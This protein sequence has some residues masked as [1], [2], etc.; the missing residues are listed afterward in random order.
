MQKI[1]ADI[2]IIGTGLTGLAIAYYLSQNNMRVTLVEARE[3][4]GGRIYTKRSDNSPPI[5]LGAT[6]IGKKHSLIWALLKELDLEVFEQKLGDTAIYEPISTSPPQLVQLPPND[7]PSYR[8]KGGT[9][10]IIKALASRLDSQQIYTGQAIKSIQKTDDLLIAKSD[11]H[12]F[13]GGIIISTLPPFLFAK[14][15]E[16]SPPL[17]VEL[18]NIAEKTHTWMGESIKI[19][20][21]FEQPFWENKHLSGTIVSNVG[22]IPEMYD[23]S[24][25]E[26]SLFALKGF[27]NGVYFSMTKAERLQIILHQLQKYYGKKASDFI[28]YEELIWKK[29]PFT[30]TDYSSHILPHQNN[31]NP[32]YQKAFLD[33]SLYLAGSETSTQF[34]GYMEGAVRSAQFIYNQIQARNSNE[35][36]M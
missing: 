9:D 6:W 34:G 22:P 19:A 20:L 2:I 11:T 13:Y 31:G 29:E 18:I 7:A 33:N 25:V 3:R 23:H 1:E 21:S 10:S 35:N 14:N 27:L 32:L 15:I 4:L 16:V 17:P 36:I 26:A 30:S 12:E 24:N 28:K 8:I 5:E